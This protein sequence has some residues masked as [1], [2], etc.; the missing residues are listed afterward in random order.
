MISRHKI[1]A[2][3]VRFGG[4][5]DA[6]VSKVRSRIGFLGSL[7]TAFRSTPEPPTCNA[8][9]AA[10]NLAGM[11]RALLLVW[12]TLFSLTFATQASDPAR[13][14]CFSRDQGVWLSNLDGTNARKIV[15]GADPAISPDGTRV[16][17]TELGQGTVR[18]IAVIDLATGAKTSFRNLPSDNAY[19]P[20][21]SPDGKQLVCKIFVGD[22]WRLGSVR[23]DGT[24]FKFVGELSPTNQDFESPAWAPDGQSIY[25]QDLANI[26]RIDLT[27]KVLSQ[28][29]ISE[30]LSN[31]DMNSGDRIEPS[32]DGSHLLL[33]AD[34][35]RDGPIRKWE[36]PP[37]AVFLFEIS[38]GKAKRISPDIPYAWEP[39][40]LSEQEYLF[41][42]TRDGRHFEI[43][44]TSLTGGN[45]Q[46]LIKN[47]SGVT[48]SR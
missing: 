3:R 12:S 17:Y 18:H 43:Y 26:Y 45:P 20:V 42:G 15:T 5:C 10:C 36:G 4:A 2:L 30:A 16:A 22:H 38:E 1:S 13:R 41:T 23:A 37:P 6:A 7:P 32:S 14:L 24:A 46:V 33:D 31:A 39:C 27:G 47:A 25:C 48:V 44:K 8:L 40:W 19:G 28:W 34:L 9:P 29:K 35:D 21:W 11:F